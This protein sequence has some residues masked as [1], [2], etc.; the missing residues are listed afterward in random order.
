M[1][2]NDRSTER[3][4]VKNQPFSEYGHVAYQIKGSEAYNDMLTNSLPLYTPLTPGVG[5]TGHF[6]LFLKV[7]MKLIA[8]KQNIMQSISLPFNTPLIPG[9]GQ[10]LKII[11]F[12]KVVMLH[13]K[14]KGKKCRTLC[15]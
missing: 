4:D 2:V 11:F 5:S 12:L 10:K 13:I 1:K 15:K 8:M 6:F 9:W 3:T 7:V 14:L